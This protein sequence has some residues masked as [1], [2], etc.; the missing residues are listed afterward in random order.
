VTVNP[1]G[2]PIKDISMSLGGFSTTGT[3][4][5]QVAASLPGGSTFSVGGPGGVTSN[6]ASF[7]P[8]TSLTE[9]LTSSVNAGTGTVTIQSFTINFSEVPPTTQVPEPAAFA[10]LGTGLVGLVAFRRR[11]R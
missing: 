8:V 7:T 1:G 9:V 6:E 11:I 4:T 3:G 2:Q 10:L 5:L